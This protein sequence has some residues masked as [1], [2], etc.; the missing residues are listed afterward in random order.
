[1]P[2]TESLTATAILDCMKLNLGYAEKLLADIPVEKF[3]HMPHPTMNHPAFC[4]GHLALYPDKAL[5]LIGRG[6]LTAPRADYEE[7]FSHAATYVDDASRYPA[8]DEIIAY[9][10]E[11]HR[12]LMSAL[13]DVAEA[14][15]QQPHPGPGRTAEMFSTIGSA[16][17]FYMNNHVM[18]HLGQI[19][20]W[21]RAV[22]L[23]SAM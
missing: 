19:S 4:I 12:A 13:P 22:G 6:A 5:T 15:L 14:T 11:R 3:A 18:L 17:N 20:A 9:F 23:P 10:N 1:M 7:L 2:Q 21:R 8:R 16:V